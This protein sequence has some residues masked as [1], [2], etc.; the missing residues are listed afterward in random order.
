MS[1]PF[2]TKDAR[3]ERMSAELEDWCDQGAP[4]ER[5]TLILRL[6]AMVD[7]DRI[8]E[9]LADL[10]IEVVSSGAAVIVG[11]VAC[12]AARAASELPGVMRLDEPTRLQEK[13]TDILRSGPAPRKSGYTLPE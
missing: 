4:E 7:P 11:N 8:T 9:E 13:V 10:D 6:D 3:P 2:S 5:R 1:D 12:R